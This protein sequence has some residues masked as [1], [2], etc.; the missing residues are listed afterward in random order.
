M[1]ERRDVVV[2][3]LAL[4][5]RAGLPAPRGAAAPAGASH[6]GWYWTAVACFGLALLAKS[7]VVGLPLVLLALD[8][9]PLAAARRRSRGSLVEKLPFVVLSAAVAALTRGH[10]RRTRPASRAAGTL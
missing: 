4:P 6:R 2:G 8:R 9:Y 3:L 7:I 10:P 1:T 5:D